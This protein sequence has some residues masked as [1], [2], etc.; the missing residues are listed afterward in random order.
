M[1]SHPGMNRMPLN[2]TTSNPARSRYGP[3][4][5]WC[6]RLLHPVVVET[7]LVHHVHH[8]WTKKRIQLVRHA[9]DRDAARPEH[10]E[11]LIDRCAVFRASSLEGVPAESRDTR[12]WGGSLVRFPADVEVSEDETSKLQKAT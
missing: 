4:A 2:P 8:Q 1:R 11:Q 5:T 10:A 12:S 6:E 9:D 7:Q 3:Q